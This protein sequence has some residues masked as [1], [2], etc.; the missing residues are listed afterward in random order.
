MPSHAQCRHQS[1]RVI[2]ETRVLVLNHGLTMLLHRQE[3]DICAFGTYQF[4]SVLYL[5]SLKLSILKFC[6]AA[7]FALLGGR[8]GCHPTTLEYLNNVRCCP[9]QRGSICKPLIV[10]GPTEAPGHFKVQLLKWYTKTTRSDNVLVDDRPSHVSPST[11]WENAI[12]W[13]TVLKLL[14][15]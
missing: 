6:L 3:C 15:G 7:Q 11:M 1:T 8:R 14:A 13:R 10:H 12:L 9:T 5:P 4:R 2:S